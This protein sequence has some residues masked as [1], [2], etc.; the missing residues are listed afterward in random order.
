[1]NKLKTS[2]YLYVKDMLEHDVK[3]LELYPR[4]LIYPNSDVITG[5]TF[6]EIKEEPKA[7]DD[8]PFHN[9][10]EEMVIR[11]FKDQGD[12]GKKAFTE[13]DDECYQRLVKD[14]FQS[15]V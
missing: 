8:S 13:E 4:D 10:T 15:Y 9:N 2:A 6:D 3:L 14:N 1:M 7:I 5:I 11:V 12:T